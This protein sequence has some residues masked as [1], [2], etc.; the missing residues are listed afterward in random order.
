MASFKLYLGMAAGVGK[1]YRMLQEARDLQR[2]GADIVVGL[3]VTH[4][5]ADTEAMLNGLP[6]F[7]LRQS[8]YKGK[9]VEE[10][11][12]EGLLRRR[13]TW[14]V[15]D[16]LA[17][18]NALGSKNEK[19]WQDLLDLLA[20]GINVLSAL[21]IQHLE[22]LNPQVRRITGIEVAERVPDRILQRADEVVNIDVPADELIERLREG[23][24]YKPNQIEAA[25]SNFFKQ[26]NLL[27][28]R[29]LAMREV[30]N[31]LENRI[32]DSVPKAQRAGTERI[33]LAISTNQQTAQHMLRRTAR[34]ASFLDA[35]WDVVYVQT[36]REASDKINLASQ[37]HLINNF[38]LATE[39][40]ANVVTLK[41]PDVAL[42]LAQ[43]CRA[44]E[45]TL[46][47]IGKTRRSFWQTLLYGDLVKKLLQYTDT[48]ST[49]ILII[50]L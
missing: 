44:I 46:M 43:H 24:I 19:R 2:R 25:L 14:V 28:L 9:L 31:R 35:H 41:E 6:Q 34:I 15:V 37:R 22:S 20:A 39:L 33:V 17:H 27:Q 49:D 36:P 30:A 16:E 13:P 12:L 23:K 3:A 38:K 7:P 10:L 29:E 21:N 11:D 26:E 4:G 1:T 48:T 40:G 50:G 5:R 47:V 42:A 18:T 45:A 8:F 32:G